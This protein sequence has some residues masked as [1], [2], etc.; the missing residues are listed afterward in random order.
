M[1]VLRCHVENSA[2]IKTSPLL[3]L[4]YL[5]RELEALKNEELSWLVDLL[6]SNQIQE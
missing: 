5:D 1:K 4:N 2:K 3:N 6:S